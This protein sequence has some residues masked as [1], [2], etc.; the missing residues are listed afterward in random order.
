MKFAGFTFKPKRK[1]RIIED[2]WE[3]V[4]TKV[5]R[6]TYRLRFGTN[7]VRFPN[8]PHIFKT[9]RRSDEIEISGTQKRQG[10]NPQAIHSRTRG[11]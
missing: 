3:D 6:G 8:L 10:G 5:E 11:D 1:I 2:N 9:P 4:G 7:G